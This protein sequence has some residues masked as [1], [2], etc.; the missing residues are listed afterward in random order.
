MTKGTAIE[1]EISL[2]LRLNELE[3]RVLTRLRALRDLDTGHRHSLRDALA[4]LAVSAVESE[5]A[6]AP[7]RKVAPL[8]R[9]AHAEH[10]AFGMPRAMVEALA[11]LR[12]AHQA[13]WP[14]QPPYSDT[15]AVRQ[16][17][18]QALPNVQARH[19]ET[20]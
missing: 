20:S 1:A 17:L 5:V 19:A 15:E 13:A 11:Q 6:L 18:L 2:S 4:W 3:S 10:I 7:Q 9:G 8:P 12:Q 16:L 14:E